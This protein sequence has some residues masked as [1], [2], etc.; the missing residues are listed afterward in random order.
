MIIIII[1][2]HSPSTDTIITF[3]PKTSKLIESV[4]FILLTHTKL[5]PFVAHMKDVQMYNIFMILWQELNLF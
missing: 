2:E 3:T 5:C 4:T 1:C